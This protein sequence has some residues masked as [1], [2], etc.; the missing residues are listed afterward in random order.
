MLLG[1]EVLVPMIGLP[2]QDTCQ[3]NAADSLLAG[4]WDIHAL[5]HQKRQH[6]SLGGY[7][8]YGAGARNLHF[9]WF[10]A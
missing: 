7:G 1:G 9:K 2:P 5:R 8:I 10:I 6:G 4:G 3:T